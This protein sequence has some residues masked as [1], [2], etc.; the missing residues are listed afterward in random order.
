M[1]SIGVTGATGHLGRLIVGALLSRGARP[2]DVVAVVRDP[3]KAGRLRSRGVRVAQA[4]YADEESLEDAFDGVE[5]LVFVSGTAGGTDRAR[6]HRNVV[7]AAARAGVAHIAYTSILGGDE[8]SNPIR[9]D[10]VE[11]ER[12]LR[13]SGV[14]C[15]LLRH[16]WYSEN[17]VGVAQQVAQSGVLVTSAG[18]GR[19]AT[20]SRRDFAEADAAAVLGAG[21]GVRVFELAGDEGWT[22]AQL[23]DVVSRVWGTALKVRAVSPEEHRAALQASGAPDAAVDY[24][25]A[26]DASIAEGA[27]DVRGHTLSQLIGRPTTPIEST[28][29]EARQAGN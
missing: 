3:A 2:A 26:M 28:L 24:A 6:L 22:F 9:A 5:R 11:T 23:A 15:S 18:D 1:P 14:S 17:Y 29:R 27:L 25:V 4:D 16:G 19:V 20:A 13:E 8:T 21:S 12:Y 10:H 7:D